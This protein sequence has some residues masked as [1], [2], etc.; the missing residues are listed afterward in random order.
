MSHSVM[1]FQNYA[2]NILENRIA[3]SE[4]FNGHTTFLM[5]NIDNRKDIRR[6]RMN[7][8]ITNY[9]TYYC[10]D[11]VKKDLKDMRDVYKDYYETSVEDTYSGNF[12]PPRCFYNNDMDREKY[13][14]ECEERYNDDI[15]MHYMEIS[16]KY[17]AINAMSRI[18]T[19]LSDEEFED[20]YESD[21]C[22]TGYITQSDIID[23]YDDYDCFDEYYEET[24]IEDD[25]NDF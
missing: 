12:D 14:K 18:D 9:V 13:L 8:L 3:E 2:N 17:N 6:H 20:V 11:D 21:D 7:W 19:V 24:E 15:D 1:N 4:I 25:Y 5:C 23:D 16:N 22:D 10:D